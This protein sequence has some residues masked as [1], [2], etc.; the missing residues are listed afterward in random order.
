MTTTAEQ[1]AA[2][3]A[4]MDHHWFSLA[5]HQDAIRRLQVE[6]RLLRDALARE[7][8][9]IDRAAKKWCGESARRSA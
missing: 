6:Q 5:L 7:D 3:E 9:R 1:L 8:Q 2:V 4:E